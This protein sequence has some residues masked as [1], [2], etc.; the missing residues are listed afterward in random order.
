MLSDPAF[1]GDRAAAERMVTSRKEYMLATL[2]YID[3]EFGGAEKYVMEKLGVT[4]EEVER[5][6]RVMV[7]D[8][9]EGEEVVDWRKDAE[10]VE[11]VY[12]L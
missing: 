2:E 1:D 12:K 7:V 5:I 8:V 11:R 3:S 10:A 6:K 9:E 4:K